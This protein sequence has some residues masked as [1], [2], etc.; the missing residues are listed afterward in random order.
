L[1]LRISGV[2]NVHAQ[3]VPPIHQL[4][5]L[6]LLTSLAVRAC[7]NLSTVILNLVLS[8]GL[9]NTV[10]FT[11]VNHFHQFTF[12]ALSKSLILGVSIKQCILH[13]SIVSINLQS[14]RSFD[15]YFQNWLSAVTRRERRL[16]P[17]RISF[18]L[19][20]QIGARTS[21]QLV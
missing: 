4:A 16:S 3:G 12:L 2:R 20:L 15:S 11:L 17:P 18:G 7:Q 9:S 19:R 6:P 10:H 13:M 21:K 1:K 8:Y 14:R 5:F